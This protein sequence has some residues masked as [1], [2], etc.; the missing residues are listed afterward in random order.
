MARI[1]E[2][3]LKLLP[4]FDEIYQTRSVSK[5][6]ANLGLSQSA[7]SIGLGKLRQ[8][9][10]DP[11]FV[12]TSSGMQPTP[13]AEDLVQPLREGLELVRAALRHHTAFDPKTSHRTFRVCFTDISEIVLLPAIMQRVLTTAPNVR[14]EIAHITEAIPKTL[15]SGA[16]DLAVG[17]M[18]RLEAGFR[19]QRLH[20][21]EDRAARTEFSRSGGGHRRHGAPGHRPAA[22]RRDVAAT[23]EDQDARPAA[24]D[25]LLCGQA[26]LARTLSSRS[27]KHVATTCDSGDLR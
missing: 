10:D 18:P 14:L 12:R 13:C 20:R 19:Q 22:P 17:F 25:P 11:L 6:G 16:A 3:D 15:E 4:I 27:R 2:I 8:H 24:E 26:A 9:F 23:R 21:A 5:A 7:I 1:D